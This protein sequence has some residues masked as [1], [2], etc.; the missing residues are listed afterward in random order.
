MSKGI[1]KL[2]RYGFKAL[3]NLGM[4]SPT[5]KAIDM[6]PQQKGTP[7]QMFKQLTQIGNKP[8]K[9]EMLFTGM[10][11]AFATAPKVT[12]Q[13]LKDYLAGNKTRIKETIKSKK[14]VEKNQTVMNEF[15]FDRLDNPDRAIDPNTKRSDYDLTNF[16]AFYSQGDPNSKKILSNIELDETRLGTIKQPFINR[17]EFDD[18]SN[19]F[20]YNLKSDYEFNAKKNLSPTATIREAENFRQFRDADKTATDKLDFDTKDL[21]KFEFSPRGGFNQK[22]ND[23]IYRIQG[24]NTIGYEILRKLPTEPVT[25]PF[26]RLE[27]VSSRANSFNEAKVQLNSYRRKVND[28][29]DDKLRPLHESQTLPGGKNYQELLLSLEEPIDNIASIAGKYDDVIDT[30]D[31]YL[32]IRMQGITGSPSEAALD[33]NLIK[34]LKK[35]EPIQIDDKTTIRYN[36]DTDN[37]E[38]LKRD[39]VNFS[40]TGD[41]KNVVVFARTKDRVDEEG[42]KILYTEEMQS[43][44]SQQGRKRG[45]MMGQKEKKAFINKNNPIIFGDIL[46]SIEKLKEFTNIE[47]L[48]AIRNSQTELKDSQIGQIRGSKQTIGFENDDNV[49]AQTNL[50]TGRVFKGVPFDKAHSFEDLV[51]K[52]QT[53][54][55]FLEMKDNN[56]KRLTNQGID[57]SNVNE[58]DIK[59]LEQQGIKIPDTLYNDATDYV[60]MALFQN[61]I[62]AFRKVLAKK[63]YDK[64][65]NKEFANILKNIPEDESTRN[66]IYGQ[67]LK[68]FN[69]KMF[70]KLLPKEDIN[71]FMK[72]ELDES[73]KSMLSFHTDMNIKDYNKLSDD[74]IVPGATVVDGQ[75][76][77]NLKKSDFE[78]KFVAPDIQNKKSET[79]RQLISPREAEINNTKNFDYSDNAIEQVFAGLTDL[80]NKLE[81]AVAYDVKLR[82]VSDLPSAPFIGTSERFT[83]LGIKRLLKYARDNDYDGV[84]FSSGIIH[85]KRWSEP[86]LADY[87]DVIL[88]KVANNILKGTDAK[89]EYKTIFTDDNFLK[90]F[91]NDE[92]DYEENVPEDFDFIDSLNEDMSIDMLEGGYIKDSPTIYLTPDIKEYIDSGISLYSPIVATGLAGAITSQI[93]GPEEDIIEDEVLNVNES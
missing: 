28:M 45:L 21:I 63:M 50:I 19:E 85:D 46:D 47:D 10:E 31:Q 20:K 29:D 26:R 37:I 33:K 38:V 9:E 77:R 32:V 4:F 54:Y 65:Y 35:G 5:E 79:V 84:S 86:N 83:E 74:D 57:K 58:L 48:K 68:E 90:K 76:L 67:Q 42:R 51:K 17:I 23:Y 59:T 6:L 40:H 91:K 55:K 22:D 44:M 11:D 24:N 75:T 7:Q 81:K 52:H 1:A 56:T 60:D 61:R 69:E 43:D 64:E 70:D 8:V 16:L 2:F 93:L 14:A 80:N 72:K 73:R 89:L 13:E 18:L 25:A 41:E 15:D 82:P 30:T 62:N 78:K 66:Y 87:Y 34:P 36:E 39:Y 88:P 49:L 71:K 53:K 27:S 12:S 3:D 92:L